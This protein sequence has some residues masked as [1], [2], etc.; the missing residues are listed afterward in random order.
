MTELLNFI[1]S[2]PTA[3]HTVDTVKKILISA[4]FTELYESDIT[5][6][7]DG[8]KHFTIRNGSSI[9]AFKGVANSGFMICASHS[10]APTFKL[11]V[12]DE[13]GLSNQV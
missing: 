4:G 5:G 6:F 7:A 9:I 13:R 12:V 3:Y 8:G 10:D 2:S 1:K 11:T